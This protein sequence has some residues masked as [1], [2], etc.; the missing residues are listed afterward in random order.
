MN[1]KTNW[2]KREDMQTLSQYLSVSPDYSTISMERVQHDEREPYRS[3]CL[4][5]P[6]SSPV[7]Q[8][9]RDFPGL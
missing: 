9:H 1:T 7:R 6:A 8:R 3:V 4:K 5:Y 2:Q